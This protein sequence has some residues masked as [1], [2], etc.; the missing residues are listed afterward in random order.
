MRLNG[1]HIDGF[2]IF[3]DYQVKNLG[4][5]LTVFFGPNEAGKST[6]LA[7][8]RGVL[9]G[10]GNARN[11]R[12]PALRGGR[13]GGRLFLHTTDGEFILD[14]QSGRRPP[15]RI[16]RPDGLEGT[17]AELH[18]ALGGADDQLFRSVFAFSLTE[19]QSFESLS[20]D[21]VRERI[22]AAGIVGAGRSARDAARELDARAGALFK[23]RGQSHITTLQK[24]LQA[25]TTE[26]ERARATAAAYET[27]LGEEEDAG[28][29]IARLGEQAE[30]MRWQKARATGLIE[31]WPVWNERQAVE[32]ELQ[33]LEPV[34]AFPVGAEARL[35]AILQEIKS[36]EQSRAELLTAQHD[37]IERRGALLVDEAADAVASEVDALHESLSL[38]RALL[39]QD[40]AARQ[41]LGQAKELVDEKLRALGPDWHEAAVE[42]FDRSIARQ[43]EVRAWD[44]RLAKVSAEVERYARELEMATRK[45]DELQQHRDR[46]RAAIGPAIRD[47]DRLE[48]R[49]RA[50]R[51]L[52]ANVADLRAG[53]AALGAREAIVNEQDRAAR[54]LESELKPSAR[55]WVVTLGGLATAAC[56]LAAFGLIGRGDG[57]WLIFAG[58]AL[59]VGLLTY[60]YWQRAALQAR[61]RLQR[62]GDLK[63]LHDERVELQRVCEEDRHKVADFSRRVSDDAGLLGLDPRPTAQAIEEL[64]AELA[65]Q[66]TERLEWHDR[67]LRLEDAEAG[68]AD[69]AHAVERATTALQSAEWSAEGER[70]RWDKW[71]RGVRFPEGL[72]PQGVLDY[73]EA[74]RACQEFIQARKSAKASAIQITQ[75]IGTWED[76]ARTVLRVAGASNGL[77][78]ERL[79]EAIAA[80]RKRCLDDRQARQSRLALENEIRERDARLAALEATVARCRSTRDRLF[81]EAGAIDETSFHHR[82]TTFQRRLALRA[83]AEELERQI[84]GRIGRGPEADA[85]RDELAGGRVDEWRQRVAATEAQ[86]LDL[87]RLRDEA[88]G[89]HRDAERSRRE[90]EASAD[91]ARLEIEHAGLFSELKAAVREWRIATLARTLIEET[92][93]EF[94]RTRQPAVLAHATNTFS[95]VTRERYE[96]LVLDEEAAGIHVVDNTGVRRAPEALSR[97]TAEQLYLCIRLALAAEFARRSEP[98]PLIMDDVLVNFDP[99]RAAAIAQVVADHA[100]RQQVLLFT[101]HPTTR[102][103]LRNIDPHLQIVE[104]HPIDLA[105]DRIAT[106]PMRAL[107][108]EDVEGAQA[109][110][111]AEIDEP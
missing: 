7:F 57:S 15:L 102:D 33:A 54:L 62:K 89:R 78:S 76:R 36:A 6:L 83:R 24:E 79:V 8:I 72:S 68:L 101:C 37:A 32:A 81:A 66:K 51:R 88:V 52:R 49:L 96:R 75:Q 40:A 110:L 95:F 65:R 43:D 61:E 27:C 73:F 41:T 16:I 1:W 92:L 109:G 20:A 106:A 25:L 29:E 5:G 21:G 35:A 93:G 80:L 34:D 47:D 30:G 11:P 105:A 10:F 85:I 100:R 107:P 56:V 64:D 38:H 45:R 59:L 103:L 42:A 46:L 28:R 9:F 97:G 2:G 48:E 111:P 87:Q 12:Y 84:V 31:L 4:G 98:L 22:F 74:I 26:V 55:Q 50:L 71:K 67:Q 108:F 18:R 14:R 39:Q 17:E 104:L 19:L 23:P 70:R 99:E 77:D 44:A 13:H 69:A 94:E 86:A 3:R 91:V 90:V 53:E 58:A 60:S 82:L 63:A